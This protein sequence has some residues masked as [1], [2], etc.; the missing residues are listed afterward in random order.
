MAEH[1]TYTG[2][3][4]PLSGLLSNA[5]ERAILVGVEIPSMDWQMLE[6]LDELEQ[7]ATT[8]GIQCMDRLTQHLDRP[9]PATLLGSGKVKEL[10]ELAKFHDCDA[11]IFDLELTP[12]QHR[13]LER[14]LEV[15]VLDR[16]ALILIIFGQRA[17]T[18]E[19][20][21][22]VELA[23]VEYDLPRIARLW[24]HLS[25]QRGGTQQRGEGEQQIEVDRRLLRRQ[26]ERLL[27]DLDLV[28]AQRQ[29]HRERRQHVG[30]PVIA[31]VGYTNAGK[32][33]L[34]NRLASGTHSMAENKLFAT[35]DP[36]TRRVR[37]GGG[38]EV[39][40]T[41]TVGFVQRLP[42]ILVAAFR[43]T[44]EEVAE[45]DL[46]I[47]VVDASHPQVHL[48]I[49]AVEQVLEEIGAGGLPIVVAL[50]KIDRLPTDMPLHLGG[51]AATLPNVQISAMQGIGIDK[52]LHCVSETLTSQFVA[53]DV[54][55][56][57]DRG[58]LVAQ[59]H[60]FGTIESEEYEEG[61]THL[62]GHVPGN[63]S[64]PFMTFQ[65]PALM[66]SIESK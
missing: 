55:I 16:T 13:N 47:H 51:L 27:E 36:T 17:R 40:L 10:A 12:G 62:R 44:L 43:A 19:G 56:P 46:L 38:Q 1:S 31:L 64:G 37:L 52:L 65:Q 48:Q 20:R 49:A 61:G 59:F 21:L 54:L 35:L 4:K 63:H 24:G 50:N 7:L 39:L 42:T 11:V 30:P 18:R 58:E 9:H 66:D 8:A 22:Q 32:S 29:Q 34:L 60:Q 53:L 28:R 15:Q 5:P 26:K 3:D 23:Q 57:Y 25:R 2:D 6:S 45:A 14:E 33:T 41:D